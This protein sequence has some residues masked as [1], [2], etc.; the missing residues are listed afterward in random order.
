[1][2]GVKQRVRRW[3]AAG[4]AAWIAWSGASAARAEPP[5]ELERPW[6]DAELE[7]ARAELRDGRQAAGLRRLRRR[8]AA[9]EREA[10]AGLRAGDAAAAR[11]VLD[12]WVSAPDPLVIAGRERLYFQPDLYRAWLRASAAQGDAASAREAACELLDSARATPE[13]RRWIEALAQA[14]ALREVGACLVL[15]APEAP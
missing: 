13:D 14:P 9:V 3:G 15:I 4:V 12:R 10:R 7:R 6:P 11:R 2:V 5:P 1:M 8:M